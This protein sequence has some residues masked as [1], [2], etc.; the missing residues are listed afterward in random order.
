MHRTVII[1][2]WQYRD[3]MTH[4]DVESSADRIHFRWSYVDMYTQ[5]AFFEHVDQE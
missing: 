2:T 5:C 1:G 3:E 4:V